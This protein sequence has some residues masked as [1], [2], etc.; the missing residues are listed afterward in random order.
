MQNPHKVLQTRCQLSRFIIPI[1]LFQ[2]ID[3]KKFNVGQYVTCA[4]AVQ[5]LP[6]FSTPNPVSW[7]RFALL[8]QSL[9]FISD[10]ILN[11]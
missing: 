6:S 1:N 2:L 5:S 3:L 11:N 8:Y 7:K 4:V 9:P 10:L